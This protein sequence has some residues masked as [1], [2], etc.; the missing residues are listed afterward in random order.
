MTTTDKPPGKAA[1]HST[2][3]AANLGVLLLTYLD[4]QVGYGWVPLPLVVIVQGIVWGLLRAFK[5]RE[6]ITG[7]VTP[8]GS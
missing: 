8:K 4:Q 7:V 3:L 6:P 5:T 2:E 1:I